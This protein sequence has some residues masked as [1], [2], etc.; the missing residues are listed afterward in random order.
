[1]AIYKNHA[2]CCAYSDCKNK[3]GY[4]SQYRKVNGTL[5]FKWKRYCNDHRTIKKAVIDDW[6]MEKGCE[7]VDGRYGFEC[8]AT[9]IAPEQ[10]D[11]HHRDGNK[12]NNSQ[13]NLECICGNC[14]S[15]VTVQNGDHRNR[16][17]NIVKWPDG[18]IEF[19]GNE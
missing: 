19:E 10:L 15:V 4:H 2:P 3:V 16:Y 18:I 11:I 13:E 17:N 12:H 6:K 1:M 5:G 7:N 8:T 14:H 9:I